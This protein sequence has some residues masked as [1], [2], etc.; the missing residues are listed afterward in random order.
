[1]VSP[2]IC[3]TQEEIGFLASKENSENCTW[4]EYFIEQESKF[5]RLERLQK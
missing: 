3:Q 2:K 5:L 4:K 1:M